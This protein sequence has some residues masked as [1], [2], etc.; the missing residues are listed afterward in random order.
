[1]MCLR[2]PAVAVVRRGIRPRCRGRGTTHVIPA[3]A[4][5]VDND[6]STH[7]QVPPSLQQHRSFATRRRQRVSNGRSRFQPSSPLASSNN[8]E[9]ARGAPQQ[10]S[11]PSNLSDDGRIRSQSS[12]LLRNASV[13]PNTQTTHSA[14]EL[15]A[16]QEP[17]D[18]GMPVDEYLKMASLSPWVPCPDVVARRMLDVGKAGGGTVHYDLGCGDG[19]VNFHALD[20]Y[21]VR[22]TTG[23]DVDPMMISRAEDRLARRHPRPDNVNFVA[24]DLLDA[25]DGLWERMGSS[26]PA[27]TVIT[28]YF[29]EEALLKIKPL[30]E[31]HCAAKGIRIV[32]CGYEM[33]G[34]HAKWSEVVL[35]LPIFLYEPRGDDDDDEQIPPSIEELKAAAMADSDNEV[36][37][38]AARAAELDGGGWKSGA[39]EDRYAEPEAFDYMYDP[40]ERVNG[41]W[42]TF[43]EA[44]E[45]VRQEEEEAKAQEAERIDG[46]EKA[47]TD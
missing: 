10:P 29:V 36:I 38:A 2:L 12:D 19:R 7:V 39:A 6:S 17:F 43:D 24:A 20:T 3:P 31:Q 34:W 33:R 14:A 35:G 28:C 4:F 15:A 1:M 18:P 23:I 13:R 8:E 37:E 11:A 40:N 27:N 42:D 5:A 25:P 9:S 30:L 21:G 44:D 41:G 47:P 32:T 45:W 46:K 22:E 16:D 26:D